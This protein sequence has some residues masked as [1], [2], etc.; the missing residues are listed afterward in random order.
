MADEVKPQKPEEKSEKYSKPL[1]KDPIF[2]IIATLL[3]LL[4]VSSILSGI[5]KS[6]R[7]GV[8]SQG[9]SRFTERGILLAHGIPISSIYNP[10]GV[11][12]VSVNE[13]TVYDSPNGKRIGKQKIETD[14]KVLQGPIT[15]DSKSYWYVDY[16]SDPDGWVIEEDIIYL[17]SRPNLF[18]RLTLN[19]ILS[20]YYFKI[21]SISLSAILVMCMV[22]V[23]RKIT[24]LR[25]AERKLL[26]PE[27]YNPNIGLDDNPIVN[28]KWEKILSYLDSANESDWRRAILEADIML[29]ELLDKFDLPGEDSMSE[30]LKEIEESDFLTI[31]NAWEAHKIRNQIA[32]DGQAFVL[33]Q[34]EAKRVIELYR[35]IFEEFEII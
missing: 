21:F 12:I 1:Y 25:M 17:E 29:D 28:T 35:G 2:E 27:N 30:K 22:Y 26:Y 34:R 5:I 10:V 23:I 8:F 31:N 14:G 15:E 18:E 11:N 19:I 7:S 33:T 3:V 24:A 6:I 9:L 32:H 4:L 16:D 13:T 20:T